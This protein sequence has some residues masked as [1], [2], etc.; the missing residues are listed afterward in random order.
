MKIKNKILLTLGSTAVM[1]V[2]FISIISCNVNFSKNIKNNNISNSRLFESRQGKQL[3]NLIQDKF[4]NAFLKKTYLNFFRGGKWVNNNGRKFEN[5]KEW[6]NDNDEWVQKDQYI[7]KLAAARFEKDLTRRLLEIQGGKGNFAANILK[8]I[9][10]SIWKNK[11]IN[12]DVRSLLNEIRTTYNRVKKIYPIEQR[13]IT[14]NGLRYAKIVFQVDLI[15]TLNR[16]FMKHYIQLKGEIPLEKIS[17]KFLRENVY[18]F[19][20]KFSNYS[21]SAKLLDAL[22]NDPTS[23]SEIPKDFITNNKY[24][25]G[26]IQDFNSLKFS[27][28]TSKTKYILSYDQYSNSRINLDTGKLEGT[29]KNILLSK[30]FNKTDKM[31]KIADYLEEIMF[32]D[33]K[34]NYIKEFFMGSNPWKPSIDI[35]NL[36]GTSISGITLDDYLHNFLASK[37]AINNIPYT[38]DMANFNIYMTRTFKEKQKDK[39]DKLW[40]WQSLNNQLSWDGNEVK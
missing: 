2:S 37:Q 26:V 15:S 29:K 9:E 18:D 4:Q 34:V 22:Y 39:V 5:Y 3:Q 40:S 14:K 27:T 38:R 23:T 24:L 20:N 33:N 36:A 17:D 11:N 25:N 10:Y 28:N 8:D 30:E 13:I 32:T 16:R 12:P 35:V 7:S 1:S 19:S 21:S 6:D 31:A